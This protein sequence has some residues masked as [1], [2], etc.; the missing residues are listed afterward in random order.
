MRHATRNVPRDVAIKLLSPELAR[1]LRLPGAVRARGAHR[2]AS[3][4]TRTSA[5]C[6]I[7]G[8][9]R[10]APAAAGQR[11]SGD[12]LP[13]FRADGGGKPGGTASSATTR[14]RCRKY[15]RWVEMLGS[16][17]APRTTSR[18]LVH[19]DLKPSAIVFDG[20]GQPLPDRLLDRA[21]GARRAGRAH[22]GVARVHGARAVGGRSGRRRRPTSSRSPPR[23]SDARGLVGRSKDRTTRRSAR[24]TS[25]EVRCPRTL[26]AAQNGRSGRAPRRVRRAAA[27]AQCR[28][29]A[30]LRVGGAFHARPAEGAGQPVGSRG[31]EPLVFISYDRELS[32]G[33]RDSSPIASSSRTASEI[34]SWTRPSSNRAGRF[35]PRGQRGVHR[36]VRRL[37]SGL[38]ARR[39][40]EVEM[41]GEEIRLRHTNSARR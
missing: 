9:H 16:A 22:A 34:A 37:S 6:S 32:G 11:A 20:G 14:S 33:G 39:S 10:I 19:G 23:L 12:A 17:L 5:R 7:R 18:R 15:S 24:R 40:L 2:G 8:W 30:R 29:E 36:R 3:C 27:G 13:L 31:A 38:L 21:E 28:P 1:V 25:A 26:E 4:S 35:P 41:G